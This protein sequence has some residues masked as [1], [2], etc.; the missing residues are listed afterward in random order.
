MYPARPTKTKSKYGGGRFVPTIK[1]IKKHHFGFSR[2]ST[3]SGREE[4]AKQVVRTTQQ[5][6]TASTPYATDTS[7][8]RRYVR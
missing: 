4:T 7:S 6:T 5:P 3:A 2:I 8:S 1:P